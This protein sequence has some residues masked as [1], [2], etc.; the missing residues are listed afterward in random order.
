MLM[1]N[2]PLVL[3]VAVIGFLFWPSVNKP[4]DDEVAEPA[5]ANDDAVEPAPRPEWQEPNGIDR[6]AA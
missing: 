4:A 1:R 3:L 5:E 2:L 6:H